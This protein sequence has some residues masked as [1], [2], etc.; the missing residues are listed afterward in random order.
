MDDIAYVVTPVTRVSHLYYVSWHVKL[1][2]DS[3]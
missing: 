3:S 2:I 1:K